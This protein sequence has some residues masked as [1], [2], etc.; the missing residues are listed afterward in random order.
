MFLNYI[1]NFS[2]PFA[3]FDNLNRL[4][5]RLV[6]HIHQILVFLRNVSNEERLIQITMKSTMIDSH[7]HVT[8]ISVLKHTKT[9][10]NCQRIIIVT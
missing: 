7:V 9:N 2:V 3:G 6:R 10:K 5:Q 4:L 1:T 8:Q